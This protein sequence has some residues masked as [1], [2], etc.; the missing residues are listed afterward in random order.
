MASN[1]KLSTDQKLFRKEM[2]EYAK[3]E[4]WKI[5]HNGVTTLVYK[6]RGNTVEFSIAVTSPDESKFRR[7]VGEYYALR[8]FEDGETVAMLRDDFHDMFEMFGMEDQN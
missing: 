3:H 6:D 5:A 1:T 7:K 8:R 2:R 4:K